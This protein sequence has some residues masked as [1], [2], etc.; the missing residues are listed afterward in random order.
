MD[1]SHFDPQPVPHDL[2][3]TTE[4]GLTRS[5]SLTEAAKVLNVE[6]EMLKN[7]NTAWRK[8]TIGSENGDYTL[9]IPTRVIHEWLAWEEEYFFGHSIEQQEEAKEMLFSSNQKY[10]QFYYRVQEGDDLSS[11]A[12]DFGVK[13]YLIRH[14]NDLSVIDVLSEGQKLKMVLPTTHECA[15]V[16]EILIQSEESPLIEFPPLL[17]IESNQKNQIP[18]N[19]QVV[20][21]AIRTRDHQRQDPII[22]PRGMSA[23]QY[24]FFAQD[25]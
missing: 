20:P 22:L 7:L 1:L 15:Y 9:R 6:F 5:V 4:V 12:Q 13:D 10:I 16:A 25:Q 23:A 17:R 21:I 18:T 8:Q 14:W 24:S 19:L 2:M 3:F 11:L